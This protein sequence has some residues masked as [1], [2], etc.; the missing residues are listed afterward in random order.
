MRPTTAKEL[1]RF[2]RKIEGVGHGAEALIESLQPYHC[3]AK[4]PN[5][6][7]LILHDMNR[8]DKHRELAVI[9]TPVQERPEIRLVEAR[10]QTVS[11]DGAVI[12]EGPTVFQR[13][14][15]VGMKLTTYIAFRE[16]GNE[17]FGGVL[18]GLARIKKATRDTI[19]MFDGFFP[20]G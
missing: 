5:H 8:L 16:F 11:K 17:R 6:L 18:P 3:S 2:K 19:G 1:N 20:Q 15:Y 14:M 7:L 10:L 9:T 12:I 13:Q 4:R